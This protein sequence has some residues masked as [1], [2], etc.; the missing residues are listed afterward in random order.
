MNRPFIDFALLARA[1]DKTQSFAAGETIFNA[2]DEGREFFIICAGRVAIRLGNRTLDVLGE[3]EI[4]G[5][6]A[7]IDNAPRSATVVAETDCIVVPVGEKQFLFMTS[8]T[9]YFA[10]SLMRVL[11]GRLRAANNPIASM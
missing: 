8:E 7:L 3:G 6:M 4:F 9:P 1:T 11:V 10:L 5:E 2:G